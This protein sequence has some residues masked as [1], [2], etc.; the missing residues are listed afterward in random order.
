MPFCANCGT[1]VADNDRFCKQCGSLRTLPMVE[2]QAPQYVYQPPRVA[3]LPDQSRVVSVLPQAK[4]MTP[5]GPSD[6]Y[7]IALTPTQA[8][9]AKLTGDILNNV[10]KKSQAQSKAEGKGWLGRTSDQ[11]RAV[12]SVHLRYLEM[13]PEQILAETT[14]N[15]AIDHASVASISVRVGYE[16]SNQDVPGDPYTEIGFDTAVGK[17]KYRLRMQAKD[18]AETL[19]NFYPGKITR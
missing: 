17:F 11:R 3:S 15:F 2:Q 13:T 16:L 1:S 4:M 18:V 10:A 9:M 14:S 8:I 12:G 5:T 6:I 19:N 7:T